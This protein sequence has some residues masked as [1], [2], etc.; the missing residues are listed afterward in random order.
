MTAKRSVVLVATAA[1][2]SMALAACAQSQRETGGSSASG[3]AAGGSAF[4]FGAAGAPKV[5]DPF[6]ATDG[7]TFRVS[8]QM[9]EGL[10]SFKPGTADPAPSLAK[11]WAASPDGLT[12]TFSLQEGVKFTDGTDFNADAVC[13]NFDR[14]Y[15]QTGAGATA[16]VSQYWSDN[17]GGFKGGKTP[18][19]FKSCTAKDSK[20]AV[21]T[22]S[23]V[24]SKFP[25]ILGLPSFSMQS[26]TAMDKYKANV[27]TQQGEGFAFSE[28]VT[29]HPTG[30]GPF[31]FDAYDQANKTVTLKRNESYWGSKPAISKLVF[32]IIPDESARRQELQAGSIQGYDFPNP[33]DWKA[34]QDAGNKV[35]VRPAF[36]IL[37]LGLNA[38]SNAKLKDLRVRQAIQYA[39]NRE[40]IVKTQLPEGAKAATQFIPD[41]VAGY[42]SSLQVAA[43]DKAKA[44]Q[45]L[46]DAGAAGMTLDLW[47][48]SEVSRPYMPAPQ[49]IFEAIRTDLEAVGIKVTTTTKPWN[50]G[51][52][53]QVDAGKASAFLLGW[54]GD[55][56]TAD[57]FLG[58]F[59]SDPT[60]RFATK[61]YPFAA[62]L[63]KALAD[64]DSMA[65][66][67]A[68]TKAYEDLNAK[69]MLEYLPAIPISHS[70]PAMVVA[71]NVSGITPSPLTDEKFAGVTLG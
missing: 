35:M 68:R 14:M 44:Q 63:T 52:L 15:S 27:V 19:L 32:K 20:T 46:T 40:Q 22:L 48:P 25:A 53:D 9:F 16:A 64:A 24:T 34:L 61:N 59:F 8:R 43:Y 29:A 66:T 10:V 31:Q 69:I 41:T 28:Y 12:W 56:N 7:E 11:E 57:N 65:D 23:R 5:F 26:P 71:K 1:T 3:S 37:Y 36:N 70:P 50:G 6:Y 21:L 67:A 51:Y 54:T 33:V 45:L 17:F 42:N 38:N 60:N 39:I 47:Y 4:T 58:T 30:T 55:Y 2:L 13:K 49:K 18:S 62:A